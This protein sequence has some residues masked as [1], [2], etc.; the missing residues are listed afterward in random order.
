MGDLDAQ[1][2]ESRAKVE[3][4]QTRIKDLSGRIETARSKMEVGDDISIDIENATLDDVHT[5]A[6][7]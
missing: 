6:E 4:V 3:A 2:R 5:H 1:V 7:V